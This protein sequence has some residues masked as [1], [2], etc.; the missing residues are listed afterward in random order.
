LVDDI[1]HSS[2]NV[3]LPRRIFFKTT[4]IVEIL[5]ILSASLYGASFVYGLIIWVVCKHK[6][7]RDYAL[8]SHCRMI[9]AGSLTLTFFYAFLIFSSVTI[10]NLEAKA[11]MGH[12]GMT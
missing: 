12:V 11:N 8:V 5:R 9:W 10:K 4:E 2:S 7:R 6:I 1:K 3:H